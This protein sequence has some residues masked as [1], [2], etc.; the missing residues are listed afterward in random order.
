MGAMRMKRRILA[1]AALLVLVFSAARAETFTIMGL[2]TDGSGRDWAT[3]AFFQRTGEKADITFAYRQ[4]TD[5]GQYQAAK[6]LAFASGDLPDAFFKAYLTQEEE[7]RYLVGGQLVDLA[8][9]IPESAP[10][11]QTI[12]DARADWR[13]AV[14]QPSG[15]IASLPSL[16]G[17]ERQVYLW[18]NQTWLEGLELAM[19]KTLPELEVVLR[20]FK[21]QDPNG[22]FK[23]D[24]IPVSFI[25]PWEARFF[26]HA[27][28]LTPNDYH[29][30]VDDGG[31]VRFAPFEPGYRAFVEWLARMHT[32]G[33]LD[34]DAFRQG[35]TLRAS[36]LSEQTTATLGLFAAMA[37]YTLLSLDMSD[38]YAV[39]PP[40]QSEAGQVYR[41]F[42]TGITRGTFAITST[43]TDPTA[44]LGW[45]DDLYTEAGGRAATA[46]VEGV[47]YAFDA[48]GF[49]N[50]MTDEWT[51]A[52]T[53]LRDRA[54]RTDL[55]TPG[56]DPADFQRRTSIAVE[57]KVRRQGDA[58]QS[59]LTLPFPMYWP[60]DAAREAEIAQL[61]NALGPA[62]DYAIARFATGET[63]LDD[64]SWA[65]FEENLRQLGA[66]RFT[67]LWQTTYEGS[68]KP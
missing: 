33:L 48:N 50:W 30:Y 36:T 44:L 49:W 54:I 24:E 25:G 32:E 68:P 11:V 47:D 62:V 13:A 20:A 52:T 17:Y 1:A 43:C 27:F 51:D 37:P 16:N 2:E 55:G 40:L 8:P 18:I 15:S 39:L 10:N 31:A 46:G 38:S 53:I 29:I 4:Y 21:T 34:A 64:A 9:L 7:M 26:L 65:Q 12:L 35:Q 58:I 3:N 59:L 28:G 61:Q 67:A 19:P 57:D 5:A 42:L 41:R 45:L 6:E 14:T 23:A 63:P 56:L 60:T 66:E 22:N